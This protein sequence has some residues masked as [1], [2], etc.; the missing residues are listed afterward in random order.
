MEIK[1]LTVIKVLVLGTGFLVVLPLIVEARTM[2]LACGVVR[3]PL[4]LP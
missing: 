1:N 2:K 4:R 3:E